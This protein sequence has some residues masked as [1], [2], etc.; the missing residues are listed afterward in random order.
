MVNQ[1]RSPF[2]NTTITC[3][4]LSLKVANVHHKK[5]SS[6]D[7]YSKNEKNLASFSSPSTGIGKKCETKK[8]YCRNAFR[9]PVHFVLSAKSLLIYFEHDVF[10]KRLEIFLRSVGALEAPKS[11]LKRRRR[12]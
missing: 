11:R 4:P 6:E 2:S 5:S 1:A 8:N 3:V 10:L 7:F 12:D 9:S